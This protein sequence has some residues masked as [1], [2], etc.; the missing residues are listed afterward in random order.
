[1][2]IIVDRRGQL[3]RAA[4][5]DQKGVLSALHIDRCDRQS[6]YGGIYRGRLV[7][8]LARRKGALI[9]IGMSHLV[10]IDQAQ[11]HNASRFTPDNQP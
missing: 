11:L 1:M 2:R 6:L 8:L 10:W 7:R 3:I 5:I 4:V 9:D